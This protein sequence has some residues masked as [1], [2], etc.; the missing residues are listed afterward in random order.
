MSDVNQ[1]NPENFSHCTRCKNLARGGIKCMRCGKISH[2]SCINKL[3][4][5]KFLDDDK[6]VCCPDP[7]D[8]L[9]IHHDK[10]Q[11]ISHG[12]VFLSPIT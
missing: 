3:K 9:I 11:S 5:V 4:S 7:D 6:I 8:E 1:N 10:S 2:T 12:A